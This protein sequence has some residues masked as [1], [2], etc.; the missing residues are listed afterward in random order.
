MSSY[1]SFLFEQTVKRFLVNKLSLTLPKQNVEE[2]MKY[3]TLPFQ[4]HI[5]T[6]NYKGCL[7]YIFLKLFA[8]LC[9]LIL[10]Q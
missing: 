5:V 9:L 7:K 4:G 10:L 1:P 6:T 8:D 3:K 2:Q